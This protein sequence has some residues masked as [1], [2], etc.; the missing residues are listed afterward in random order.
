MKVGSLK[1][2]S[3]KREPHKNHEE[4]LHKFSMSPIPSWEVKR[5][6]KTRRQSHFG[7]MTKSLP[8]PWCDKEKPYQIEWKRAWYP[9]RR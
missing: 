5:F 8:H 9:R 1:F 4:L 2:P 7:R 6:P 3:E